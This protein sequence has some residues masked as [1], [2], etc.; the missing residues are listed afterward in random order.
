MAKVRSV[1]LLA[2]LL[3]LRLI[4]QDN[5]NVRPLTLPSNNAG[6]CSFHA[7]HKVGVAGNMVSRTE[8]AIRTVTPGGSREISV[9]KDQAGRIVGY[10]EMSSIFIPPFSSK[11]DNIVATYAP[12]GRIS[13]TWTH[14]TVQMSDSGLTR[15]DTASLRKMRDRAVRHSTQKSLDATDQKQVRA[16]VKWLASRCP[17]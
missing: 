10:A 16:L 9:F 17:A 8:L 1:L 15:L 13:G 12:D 5:A 3:P 2:S 4:A 6:T 7:A 11:G 14:F